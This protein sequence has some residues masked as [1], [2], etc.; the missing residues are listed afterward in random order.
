[1]E[2]QSS[3]EFASTDAAAGKMQRFKSPGSAQKFLST[4]AAV[5]NIFNVQRPSNLGPNAPHASRRG[6]GHVAH[7]SRSGLTILEAPTL[8]ARCTAT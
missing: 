5:Y 3:G 7:S 4:H 8:R 6:D 1:M 2:E